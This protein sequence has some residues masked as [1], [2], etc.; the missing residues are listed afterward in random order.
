MSRRLLVSVAPG[1]FHGRYFA[2]EPVVDYYAVLGVKPGASG[3][4]IKAA[5][6]ELSKKY[7]PDR[8]RDNQAEAASKF[9]QV[10]LAYEVLGS[11]EKR[12]VYDMTRIRTTPDL[13]SIHIRRASTSAPVKK[14]TDLDIDY[15]SFEHF[16]RLNR[17][18]KQYHSHFDMP[19]EF[20]TEFGGKRREFKSTYEPPSGYTVHRDS[21]ARQREEE[22][23]QREIQREQERQQKKYPIP[24]FEQLLREKRE[25]QERENRK[26]LVGAISLLTIAATSVEVEHYLAIVQK[27]RAN[28]YCSILRLFL[29][30]KNI[31]ILD[32]VEYP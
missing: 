16:Q 24:T 18:R 15:K 20:Y 3:K 6:Y 5:F 29:N 32:L 22:E 14:Y 9:H 17:Q 11:E 23:L 2:T 27:S 1:P 31:P 13:N 19:E 7:H 12:K 25:K 28:K 8:N 21:R 10:S 4:E 26:Q 30:F